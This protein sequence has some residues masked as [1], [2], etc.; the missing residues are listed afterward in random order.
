M[1]LMSCHQ[2]KLQARSCGLE[3]KIR[4]CGLDLILRYIPLEYSL[5]MLSWNI[6]LEYSFG[7]F[8]IVY[9]LIKP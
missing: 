3:L 1:L 5:G 8:S 4:S 7:I 2:S 6:L 9:F